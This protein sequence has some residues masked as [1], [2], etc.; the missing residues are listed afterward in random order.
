MTDYNAFSKT[1][2]E[3]RKKLRWG[4][5]DFII[6]EFYEQINN[7]KIL[8]VWCGNG[9]LLSQLLESSQIHEL[10]YYG[11]DGSEGMIEEAKKN[12]WVTDFFV[13]D[14]RKIDTFLTNGFE[15][16]FFIASFHH[17][18][19]FDDRIKTLQALSKVL[20]K[21]AYIFMTNWALSSKENYEK[22][23]ECLINDSLN[24]FWSEDFSVKIGEYS[25]FYHSFSTKELEYLFKENG[26]TIVYQELFEGGRNIITVARFE[27]NSQSEE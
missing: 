24:D 17:L 13:G 2:S 18:E 26:Y 21:W 25:R 8:D 15:W 22:Y 27:E 7:K 11:I 10:D 3:S 16:V 12:H 19:T 9:R 1:F 4:E 23:R 5:I 6:Q 20:K 14:M